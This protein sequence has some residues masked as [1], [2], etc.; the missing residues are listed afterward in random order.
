MSWDVLQAC[1]DFGLK[2]GGPKIEFIF[3]G[4]EPLLEEHQILR[5][6]EYVDLQRSLG[7]A[8]KFSILTNGTLLNEDNIDGFASSDFDMQISFDGVPELQEQ[9]SVGSFSELDGVLDYLRDNHLAYY[10][11]RCA[12]ATVVRPDTLTYVPQSVAYFFSKGVP[13]LLLAPDFVS[14]YPW[15][16]ADIKR[17]DRVFD[18]IGTLSLEHYERTGEIPLRMFGSPLPDYPRRNIEASCQL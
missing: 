4:G 6:V 8:V 15:R 7:Q 9:R 10:R 3:S 17:L 5:A 11:G 14:T 1:L 12:I 18:E 16:E 13:N 2:N